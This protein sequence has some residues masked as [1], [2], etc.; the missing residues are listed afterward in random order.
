MY[1]YVFAC[2]CHVSLLLLFVLRYCYCSCCRFFCWCCMLV[3]LFIVRRM[4]NFVAVVMHLIPVFLF[5][6]SNTMSFNVRT[7]LEYC[8][9]CNLD[10]PI[11]RMINPCS[12]TMGMRGAK[13]GVSPPRRSPLVCLYYILVTNTDA[14]GGKY[15][16]ALMSCFSGKEYIGS[17]A[18]PGYIESAE[19][20]CIMRYSRR[21]TLRLRGCAAPGIRARVAH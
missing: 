16:P 12:V 19:Y 14:C 15:L 2:T 8:R 20:I 4:T 1:E 21:S 10:L 11:V 7:P 9:I 5:S 6:L 13:A 17:I 18:R 3:V